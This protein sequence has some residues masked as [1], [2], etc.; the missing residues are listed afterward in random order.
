MQNKRNCFEGFGRFDATRT[1]PE[2]RRSDPKTFLFAQK[3]I[4]FKQFAQWLGQKLGQSEIMGSF[5]VP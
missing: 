1:F 5:L 4:L 2:S 3:N